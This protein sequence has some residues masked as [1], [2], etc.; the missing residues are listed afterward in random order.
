M[1]EATVTSACKEKMATMLEKGKQSRAQQ[2]SEDGELA[3]HH[4]ADWDGSVK[5]PND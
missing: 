3:E 2:G 1:N 4:R 5:H